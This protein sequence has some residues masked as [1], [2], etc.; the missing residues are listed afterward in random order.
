MGL[1]EAA[2]KLR[3]EFLEDAAEKLGCG[4]IAPPTTP[5]TTPRPCSST[6]REA[7]EARGFAESRRCGA[8]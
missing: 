4:R 1:E 2:R 5:T 7:P 3:Y 6:W 8:I